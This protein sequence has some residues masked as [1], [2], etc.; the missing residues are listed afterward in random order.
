M[1]DLE[2]YFTTMAKRPISKWSNYFDI[3]EMH[4]NRYRGTNVKVLEIGIGGGGSLQM[5]KWYFGGKSKIFGVDID[6]EKLF[7]EARIKTFQC[8]QGD[9]NQLTNLMAELPRMDIV[10][11]DGGHTMDQQI[12][13]FQTVYPFIADDGVYLCEDL[14]TSFFP[15]HGGGIGVKK[16]MINYMKKQ[17]DQLTAFHSRDQVP[18]TDFTNSVDSM[19]FY[20][21]V[22]VIEKGIHPAPE[23]VAARVK[24]D[25]PE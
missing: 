9:A 15:E 20:N 18:M 22:V 24:N 21:G 10:I 6:E 25:K 8:D 4:F 2:K 12:T 19:H 3:Y 13:T 23:K 1:N 11:D 7:T 16:T 5:W 14:M 17:V